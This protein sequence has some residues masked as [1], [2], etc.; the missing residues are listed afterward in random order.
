MA[1]MRI[2]DEVYSKLKYLAGKAGMSMGNYVGRLIDG[3]PAAPD[4]PD[5]QLHSKLDAIL[6]AVTKKSAMAP[7]AGSQPDTPS[8]PTKW[9]PVQPNTAQLREM[10]GASYRRVKE[11]QDEI[12]ELEDKMGFC[13]DIEEADRLFKRID[14]LQQEKDN[15]LLEEARK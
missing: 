7:P 8:E 10:S 1:N 11:I 15:L 4:T 13:Q 5:E 3:A 6:E 14:E 12:A 2:D 9:V